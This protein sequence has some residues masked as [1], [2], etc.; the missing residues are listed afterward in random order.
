MSLH[1]VQPEARSL[2]ASKQREQEE[3][4]AHLAHSGRHSWQT[5]LATSNHVPSWQV[6]QSGSL[7]FGSLQ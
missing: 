3:P 6:R 7:S 2:F 5:L 4:S 1:E